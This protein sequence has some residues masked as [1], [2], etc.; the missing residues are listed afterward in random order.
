MADKKLSFAIFGNDRKALELMQ[1]WEMLDYLSKRNADVFIEET[2]YRNLCRDLNGDLP[3]A[4]VFEGNSFETD[5]AISL[6]GDGTFLRAASKVGAKNIPIIGVNMGRLG[7]LANVL[8]GEVLEMLD[9]IYVGNFDIEE[10]SVIK[11]STDS[12]KFRDYPFA[13]NDI[14][15]LKR[16][17][18]SMIS[19]RVSVGGEYVVTYLADGLII[20]TPTGSTAYSL[21]NG[22]PI[23][24]PRSGILSLTPVAP[25]SLNIRPIVIGDDME[26]KLEVESRSHSFLAAIDGR[27][28]R[29]DE[30]TTVTIAKAPFRIRIVKRHNHRYFSTLR[31]KLMWGA[32][33]RE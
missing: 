2:F 19:I 8:P 24:V 5:Y 29:V 4:G 32:D 10:R 14:A 20:S 31:S 15:I 17:T 18:A 26:I 9:E 25:H 28:E 13:L 11:L 6:G 16:D 27:S 33:S 3:V 30:G 12:E 22:G 1:V 7:F 21:S 23:M